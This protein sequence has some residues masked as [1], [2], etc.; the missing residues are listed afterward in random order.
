MSGELIGVL[1]GVTIVGSLN[2]AILVFVFNISRDL[3]SLGV[4]VDHLEKGVTNALGARMDQ[5]EEEFRK[6]VVHL[7]GRMTKRS[8]EIKAL[9]NETRRLKELVAKAMDLPPD[10]LNQ[11]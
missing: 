1:A 9:V 11:K 7:E 2:I 6:R 3:G 8:D 4:R 5:F 10:A